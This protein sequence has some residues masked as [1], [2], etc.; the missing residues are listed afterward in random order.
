[1]LP[2]HSACCHSCAQGLAALAA[3]LAGRKQQLQAAA[4]GAQP[5]LQ[6][7][8]LGGNPDLSDAAI[9]K[10]A[11]CL[12]PGTAAAAAQHSSTAGSDAAQQQQQWHLDLAETGAGAE[13]VQA[14]ADLPGLQQLS[15]FGCKLGAAA[16]GAGEAVVVCGCCQLS[17]LD[18]NS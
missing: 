3:A 5:P 7:L 1:M 4:P 16:D 6:Q 11:A 12:M 14:L 8:L 2:A 10:L 9:S 15:L 17:T 13:A 18:V